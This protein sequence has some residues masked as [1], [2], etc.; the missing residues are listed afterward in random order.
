MSMN[1]YAPYGTK[2]VYTGQ[3][4]SDS[5]KEFGNKWLRMGT[6][7]TIDRTV[8][9]NWHTDVY[10]VEEPNKTFNSVQFEELY[11]MKSII[12]FTDE[13]LEKE[14]HDLKGKYTEL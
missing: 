4:G 14:L 8:V 9:H 1:I 6:E 2:V 3:G 10:L 12:D 5:E 11:P 13:E 7:Y